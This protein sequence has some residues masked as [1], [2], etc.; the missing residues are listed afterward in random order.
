MIPAAIE[1]NYP[2]R[3]HKAGWW[4]MS[5]FQQPTSGQASGQYLQRLAGQDSYLQHHSSAGPPDLLNQRRR[6]C[7]LFDF[8]LDLAISE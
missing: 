8:P 5:P 2:K 3:L 1:R 6:K 7:P 4:P